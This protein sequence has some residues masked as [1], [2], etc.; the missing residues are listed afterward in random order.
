[1]PRRPGRITDVRRVL[2]SRNSGLFRMIQVTNLRKAY[3]SLVAVGGVSFEV[4]PGET[5][6]L[7]GPNGAGKTTTILM[8]A[9]ALRPDAGRVVLEGAADP[10]LPAVRGRLGIAPQTL[11]VYAELTG[12]EN[13]TFF[14]KLYGL[15][16][17]A[18]RDR[19]AWALRFAG[20]TERK[21]DRA[22]TYSGGMQRRLNLA[23]ALVHDPPVLFLDEPPA[24]VDPQS[25]NHLF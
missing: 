2:Y 5:F 20:L 16:G 23:C 15:K 17:A 9:G 6:G 8:M 13:L 11:A 14:G 10:T 21:N 19:V 12:E 24:G 22:G 4:R 3:G 18:L 7:L 25:R 1:M